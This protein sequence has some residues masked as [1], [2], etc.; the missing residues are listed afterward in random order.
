M[1]ALIAQKQ[2]HGAHAG[3]PSNFFMRAVRILHNNNSTDCSHLYDDEPLFMKYGFILR[4]SMINQG[5]DGSHV[6]M[7]LVFAL[8]LAAPAFGEQGYVQ[9]NLVSDIPGLADRM[10]MNLVNPWGIVHS[11]GSPWWVNANGTGLSLVYNGA[12]A[13]FPVA[14]P[15]VVTIP[16]PGVT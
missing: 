2:S 4:H 12:G 14:N 13:A 5:S 9:H 10:D 6:A 11:A 1:R 15:L 3:V 7:T 8:A 16:P